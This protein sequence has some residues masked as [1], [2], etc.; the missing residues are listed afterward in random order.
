[1]SKGNY[2]LIQIGKTP[3]PHQNAFL[4]QYTDLSNET[5]SEYCNPKLS[6]CH[7]INTNGCE[8]SYHPSGDTPFRYKDLHYNS[9]CENCN[10]PNNSNDPNDSNKK[11]NPKTHKC[12]DFL[13]VIDDKPFW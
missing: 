3:S 5:G 8:N 11:C 6:R 2:Q 9:T 7:K 13:G 4:P 10:N 1:M 12:D